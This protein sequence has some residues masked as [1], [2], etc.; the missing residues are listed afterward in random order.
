MA[1]LVCAPLLLARGFALTHDMVFVPGQPFKA[2]WLGL[3]G[4]VPR[5]VPSDALVAAV[6]VG[7]PGDLL[8]KA[9]LLGLLLLAGGG[10]ALMVAGT[11]QPGQLAASTLFVWNPFVFERLAMGQWALLCGYAALPWVVVAARRTRSGDRTGWAMLAV[12]LCA[13]AFTSPTGGV[14]GASVC[15]CLLVGRDSIRNVLAVGL[16]LVVNLPWIVPSLLYKGAIPSDPQGVSAFAA[17]PDTPYGVIGSLLSLGGIWN[18]D[19]VPPGRDSWVLAGCLLL[20]CLSGVVGTR[21]VAGVGSARLVLLAG[22]G[23]GLALLP[24][25]WG[26][27]SLMRWVDG[28]VPGGGLLRDSQKWVALLALVEAVGLGSLVAM[29]RDRWPRSRQGITGWLLVGSVLVPVAVTVSLAWGLSGRLEPTTYPRDWSQVARIVGHL[30]AQGGAGDVAVLPWSIYRQYGWNDDRPVL[31]PA[32][33]YLPGDVV[34]ADTLLV[35]ERAIE[36]EDPW[37]ARIGSLLAR[38]GDLTG[39]L[40]RLGIGVV[41]VE[42]GTPGIGRNARLD[43]NLV[44][45]GRWLQ[46][47]VLG[48][49]GPGRARPLLL[50]R[51]LVVTGDAAAG[52]TLAGSLVLLAGARVR[53]YSRR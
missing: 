6:E 7:V 44:F 40:R 36:G 2:G 28:N 32:P 10:A 17:H 31:D 43:G 21:W 24:A 11:G 9:I 25:W 5:A 41:V 13:A 53:R 15:C 12:A 20:V 47:W 33:R 16:S 26:G 37:A 50:T 3:D 35:G 52:A 38:G 29:L 34:I 8:Q 19:V 1:V 30:E 48:S 4:S 14:L 42:R 46:V 45:D 51:A 22:I 39:G 18:S 23:L 27:M 49:P